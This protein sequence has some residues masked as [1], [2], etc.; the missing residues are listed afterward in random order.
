M[1]RSDEALREFE[2]AATLN[3]NLAGPHFQLCNPY[4][5]H[6][7]NTLLLRQ[8]R[9]TYNTRPALRLLRSLTVSPTS[10]DARRPANGVLEQ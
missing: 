10:P 1:G 4:K 8:Y 9:D 7:P 5:E 6:Y 2:L 3:P